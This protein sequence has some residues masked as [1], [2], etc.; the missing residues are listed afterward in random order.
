MRPEPSSQRRWDR[1]LE[2]EPDVPTSSRSRPLQEG[3]EREPL[4]R[5]KEGR[6]VS[7]PIGFVEI[8]RQEEAR[9]VQEQR[10]D[11][12]DEWLALRILAR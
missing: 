6:R 2:E 3:W 4:A 7:L 8:Y 11:A 12:R 1:L 5:R 9:F 10:V